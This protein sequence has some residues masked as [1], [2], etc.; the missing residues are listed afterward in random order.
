MKVLFIFLL[1]G[2]IL[3]SGCTT[4][5][6]NVGGCLDPNDPIYSKFDCKNN[7]QNKMEKEFNTF[8]IDTNFTDLVND[9]EKCINQC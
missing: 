2:L 3:V 9:Y 4:G 1:I 6:R 7:C 5:S 8:G